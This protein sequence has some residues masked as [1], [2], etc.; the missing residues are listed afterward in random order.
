LRRAFLIGASPE[1]SLQGVRRA[2]KILD[3]DPRSDW[4]VGVDGGVGLWS[5]LGHQAHVGVGDRD[6]LES[7]VR[8]SRSAVS[9]IDLPQDKDRSD[10]YF[11]L[12][13]ALWRGVRDVVSFGVTLGRPDHHWMSIQELS[14]VSQEGFHSVT[15]Y[16]SQGSY[17]FV[18]R[19]SQSLE[20]QRRTGQL[21]S[22]IAVSGRVMGVST[23][24]LRFSLKDATLVPGSHGLSNEVISKSGRFSVMVKK[25][26]LM[27]FL[28]NSSL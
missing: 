21:A 13:L 12:K 8:R 16:D 7:G 27:V 22:L 9:W 23:R 18:S 28:P 5:R 24:G 11:A 20:L 17:H 26:G 1:T 25:G 2:L 3:F 19:Q 14:R 15:A 10:L 6:S 4:M